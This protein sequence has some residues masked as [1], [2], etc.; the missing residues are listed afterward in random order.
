V[1]RAEG[2]AVLE[3][4]HQ[5]ALDWF[6]DALGAKRQP[7]P[8]HPFA[9]YDPPGSDRFYLRAPMRFDEDEGSIVF[10]A[11]V[12]EGSEVRITSA[13]REAVLDGA[14]EAVNRAVD[15]LQGRPSALLVF[16]CAARKQVLGTRTYEELEKLRSAT[17]EPIP[18]AGFYTYG[19]IA[20]LAPQS[21]ARYHNETVVA[22]LLGS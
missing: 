12:P 11:A 22:V 3:I 4:D 9:V 18:V 5:R 13:S 14:A 17:G 7:S 20:A 19:E 2:S 21:P 16:S 15:R 10:A 1:T 8:E 6:R